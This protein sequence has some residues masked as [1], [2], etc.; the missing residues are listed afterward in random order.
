MMALERLSSSSK[1]KGLASK[2]RTREATLGLVLMSIP[3]L[4][5]GFQGFGA[6]H[7]QPRSSLSP[8]AVPDSL[9]HGPRRRRWGSPPPALLMSSEVKEEDRRRPGRDDGGREP[10]SAPE[11]SNDD[12][13]EPPSLLRSFFDAIRQ[14][15]GMSTTKMPPIQVDDV[16]LLYFDVFLIINLVVS[17]GFWV[18]HRTQFQFLGS[19]FNEGC[20]LSLLWMASGLYT[21]AFLDSAVDGHYGAFDERGGPKA[22]GMLGLQTFINAI[23]L[24][25]LFALVTAAMEHRPVGESVGEQIMPLEIGFGIILMSAWRFVHSS[26]V[27]RV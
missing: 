20:L 1:T 2:K 18:V 24:R 8:A 5:S 22:A 4:C 3:V 25:L 7:R 17:I 15:T 16:N 10:S 12:D 21:G 6:M 13:G 9:V 27:P 11:L 23:N 26:I 14:D 19:A